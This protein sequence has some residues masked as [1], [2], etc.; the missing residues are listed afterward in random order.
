MSKR[1]SLS[2]RKFI[3][4]GSSASFIGL[5]Q[6]PAVALFTT[7]L[8]GQSQ[9]AWAQSLGIR[10]RALVQ[11]L[12][13]G[14]PL[15]TP[16]DS[17]LTPYST[18]GFDRNPM[19]ATRFQNIGG[20]NAVP[21]YH[22]VSMH[23]VNV[24]TMWS[25]NL[26]GPSGTQ[27][28]MGSLLQNLISI[29][30]VTT[31]NAGHGSSQ[32][33]HFLAPGAIKSTSALP[34][35]V[36]EDPFAGINI[37]ASGYSFRSTRSKTAVSLGTG[38]NMLTTLLDPFR[39]L[40]T[41]QFQANKQ[42]LREAYNSILRSLDRMARE[43]HPGAEALVQNRDSALEL[44][45]Y[46]F[47]ALGTQWTDL[48]NKYRDIIARAIFDP[49]NPLPGLTDAPI[50][51]ESIPS[52]NAALYRIVDTS[53]LNL[54]QA[55]DFRTCVDSR[56]TIGGLAESFAFTEYVLLNHLSSSIAF[57][58]GGFGPLIRPDGSLSTE[59]LGNDQHTCGVYPATFFN[60][61]RHR[62]VYAGMLELIEQLKAANLFTET[63]ISLSGEFNRNPR[64]DMT[65]SDHGF[66]G[67]VL[68]LYSGAFPGPLMIGNLMNDGRMGWGSGALMPQLGGRQL[69]LVD[70][71]V[72]LCHLVGVPPVFTSTNTL[73]TLGTNGLVSNIG[74]TR[75]I[76]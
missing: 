23:G 9:K 54:H 62:A 68:N 29:Q 16:S 57:G 4:F 37:N 2:R 61:L 5:C 48:L 34:A 75:H 33:W 7:I 59:S 46:N 14:S 44:A 49:S 66:T 74:T 25:Y 53:T 38:G 22:T 76:V 39:P 10:P 69:N 19:V 65:G 36:S 12:E 18:E 11:I 50:G 17:F 32:E 45:A 60:I 43:G 70:T 27:R 21:E 73:V 72:T 56:T 63:I 1:S 3:S 42:A 55:S 71:A 64:A 47:A 35:D 13:G 8:G 40:G 15:R 41:T 30:G 31:R 6:S 52:R 20:R 28:P 58:V 51:E 67:K 24:P 26:P